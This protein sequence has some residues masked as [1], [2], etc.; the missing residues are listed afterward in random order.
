[1]AGMRA[2]KRVWR[3]LAAACA[4]AAL[5][6]A[7]GLG[8]FRLA[9]DL[10]PG[11]EQRLV[12]QLR[13]ATG[14]RV[15]FDSLYARVGRYGPEI[16]FRGARVLPASGEEP[17]I[18]AA[19]GRVSLAVFRSL[20]HR[21][22]EVG[23]F[24]L[25]QARL[26]FVIYADGAVRLV[27]QE[28]LR[29]SPE[30]EG[31]Q[32]MTLERLPRGLFVVRDATL[33]VLDLRAGQ[34]QFE[35]TGVHLALERSGDEVTLDGRIELPR[36]L[37][38]SVAFEAGVRGELADPATLRWQGRIAARELDL[39]QWA[40]LLPA[41]YPVPRAGHGSLEVAAEG[42]GRNIRALRVQ[43][44]LAD[45]RLHT[46]AEF[47]RV[48][49]D[50]RLQ[51]AAGE[52]SVEASGLELSRAAAPWKPTRL[53]A[54]LTV[55]DG[56]LR[57]ASLRADYLRIENLVALATLAPPGTARDL[58]VALAPRGELAGLDF[59][60][61][62][63]GPGRLPDI[64]GQA[65]FSDLGS[66]PNG[67]IPGLHGLD[68]S[69]EGRGAGGIVQIATRDGAVVWPL[70]WRA[71]ADLRTANG[72][73]E[74]QRGVDG[75][76]LWL[77]DA[78]LD[79]G[80]GR[81]GGRLR[82]LL[83]PGEVPLLDLSATV[84]DA[85]LTEVWRFL[86]I[87]RLKPGSI[88]WIDAA[89]RGGRASGSVAVT[90]PGRG[91]PYRQGE[92][93]FHASGQI[94]GGRLLYAT[95]WPEAY[96]L[97]AEVAFDG[98]A[99]TVTATQGTVAGLS[100]RRAEVASS[101]LRDAVFGIRVSGAGD[102]GRAIK[103]LQQSPLAAD[104]GPL[105]AGLSGRGPFS[106]EYAMFLPARD[107]ERR[108][109]SV[110]AD[111]AGVTLQHAG[112]PVALENLT[113]RF[114]LRDREIEAPELAGSLL[115]GPVSLRVTT[116]QEDGGRLQTVVDA[117]GQ[118]TAE[119]LRPAAHLPVNAGLA[120]SAEWQGQL[121]IRRPADRK[122]PA[123]GRLH[124]TSE[125]HGLAS[126]LPAPFAKAAD[127]AR[128]LVVD[129]DFGSDSAPRVEAR[130]G[131]DVHA[132]LLWRQ[133]PEDPPIERGL[134][135]FGGA[136]PG[137]LPDARGLW[138]AGRLDEASLSDVL[139]LRWDE[140]AQHPLHAWFAGGN[141]MIRKFEALGYGFTNFTGRL[142]SV[143]RA[144]QADVVAD[145][146]SGRVMI[147]Q[148]LPGDV[149]MT[150]DLERLQ[151]GEPIRPPGAEP[152]PRAL[153]SIR[154]DVRELR[155]LGRDF[156]HVQAE[157]ARGTA[158]LTLNRFTIRHAAYTATGHGSWLV[159]DGAQRCTL[160]FEADSD[161]VQGVLE[162]MQFGPAVAG[163]KG[164][165]VASVWWPGPPESNAIERVSGQLELSAADGRLISV[166]PGAGR[167]LGLMSIAHLPRRLA[168][169]FG[170]LTGEGLSFDTLRGTFQ[171][172]SGEATT[173]DLVLR[174]SSAEIG[175][176]GITSLRHQTYD[177]TAVVTGQVGASLGV[178]GAL[179]GGPAVGAALLLFSRIFKEPLQGA[180]RG[181]YRITG[182]WDEPQVRRIDARE[183]KETRQ[184]GPGSG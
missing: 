76:R 166:E 137:A 83:R 13:E 127:T 153:P 43:P 56:R 183:L 119:A 86:P 167:I 9:I 143:S 115:G 4:A 103:L 81:A 152:D 129:L 171:L 142:Q 28:S 35:L 63:A 72:R 176:A 174:G 21:R 92:G 71:P 42:V 178:A 20:L 32:A 14:L 162:A 138:L 173:D 50:L 163:R 150:L 144:W 122:V 151:L 157:L 96:N 182:T 131:R 87:D 110:V 116:R 2:L 26:H 165:V 30:R 93:E 98:P 46:G 106:G 18:S 10:L 3:Y 146:V 39:A 139:D 40:A 113:G 90:G 105:F 64:T 155:H 148:V 132:L 136:A 25:V 135:V 95:G 107:R 126:A 177:Q 160:E 133:R 134:V 170:D 118:F 74:W 52:L 7:L 79:T 65:R 130:L 15:R 104:L 109:V 175:I 45:L 27:G 97:A 6:L 59:T 102:A 78:E 121:S 68:G 180:T 82:V 164:R 84:T 11:Y 159:Q 101:D 124:V 60:V 73:L 158:G 53:A 5:L 114:W 149:P 100:I 16:A 58:V 117:H 91:F 168:L 31:S 38:A 70:K 19:S 184:A 77:D 147:P 80:Y 54:R 172:R 145:E 67:R 181:Y 8:A 23:R 85:D 48:A 69:I 17:L 1:M 88:A 123:S 120:G 37:G 61:D 47:T 161:N 57:S 12:E 33:A 154:I 179:A 41:G 51:R 49:G 22:L 111:L 75:V 140:P 34:G 108:T 89:L 36:H 66:E 156:G 99:M 125:L 29:R 112:Q 94:T 169:D 55:R 44:R 128:P 62:D 141:L 24:M